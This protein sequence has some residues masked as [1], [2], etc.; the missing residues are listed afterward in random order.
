MTGETRAIKV[1]RDMVC[2]A[3]LETKDQMVSAGV[4]AEPLT[5]SQGSQVRGDMWVGRDYGVT[6]VSEGYRVSV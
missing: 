1:Q 5:A 3:I 6:R 2:L 4:L